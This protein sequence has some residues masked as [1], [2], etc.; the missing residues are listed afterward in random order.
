MNKRIN[1]YIY[2]YNNPKTIIDIVKYVT[3][4]HEINHILMTYDN[5]IKI[6]KP[7]RA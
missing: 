7:Y 5:Q 4:R 3:T 1:E 2:N 6:K